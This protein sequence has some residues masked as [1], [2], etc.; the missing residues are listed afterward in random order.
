MGDCG[1]RGGDVP[2][3][4]LVFRKEIN[5]PEQALLLV[6]THVTAHSNAKDPSKLTTGGFAI[7]TRVDDG[8]KLSKN[9]EKNSISVDDFE[10]STTA[11]KLL[12][13]GRHVIQV[14]V[15]ELTP[16]TQNTYGTFRVNYVALGTNRETR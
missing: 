8:D 12:G 6:S 15:A 11:F 3:G 1:S 2:K 5:L 9:E 13:P 7:A 10:I 4:N 16:T 14:D